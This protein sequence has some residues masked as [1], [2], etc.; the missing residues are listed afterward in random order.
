MIWL[1]GLVIVSF[2]FLGGIM[3]PLW[4]L[5]FGFFEQP[6]T[7]GN[8]FPKGVP[9]LIYVI[10]HPGIP[11]LMS[12]IAIA[13]G[14]VLGLSKL[15]RGVVKDFADKIYPAMYWLAVT[16]GGKCFRLVQTGN[17]KHYLLF[18]L[19]ALLAG[20]GWSVFS[21]AGMRAVLTGPEA[22]RVFEYW[23]GILI[24]LIVCLTAVLIP[25]TDIRIV[26]I[27]F[28]GACGFAVVALYLVYQAPDLAL[29][30]LMFEIISVIL[31]VIVL[32][33]LPKEKQGKDAG[34]RWRIPIAV[35]V[36]LVFGW[37][38]LTAA[39]HNRGNGLFADDGTAITE[40]TNPGREPLGTTLA[41][42]SYGLKT[43]DYGNPK[44]ETAMSDDVG[45]RGGGGT[46]VVNVILVDFRGF[47]TLGE[48]AVL[49]LAA[50]GVWSMLPHRRRRGI[51]YRKVESDY[52]PDALDPLDPEVA[53]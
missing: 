3:T 32:R 15:W 24:G 12:V 2:Q 7:T 49:G 26:R 47:D 8:Y 16:G 13:G 42:H 41:Q 31:F 22:A 52:P 27:V 9:D 19:I 14:V 5:V 38:T 11:L 44:L 33:L 53:T 43:D 20:F 21:D 10:T 30:Q 29:T 25:M 51:E 28:L 6:A 48:I 4:N 37:M 23:P 18:V 36:G 40:P 50:M 1:P 46:N 45:K 39:S 34:K 35:C 17:L